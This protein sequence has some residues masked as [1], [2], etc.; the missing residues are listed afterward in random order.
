MGV[1]IANIVAIFRKELQ[2]YLGSPV[3]YLVAAIF[4]LLSGKS[5]LDNLYKV[6]FRAA[7]V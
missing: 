6:I 7:Y 5:F 4:W 1:V 2:S 3:A